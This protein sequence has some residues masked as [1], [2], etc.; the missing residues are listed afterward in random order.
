[1]ANQHTSS[2][3][4]LKPHNYK[5]VRKTWETVANDFFNGAKVLKHV[6]EKM[7]CTKCGETREPFGK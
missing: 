5:I 7:V 3:I 4:N 6:E 2:C 1:M